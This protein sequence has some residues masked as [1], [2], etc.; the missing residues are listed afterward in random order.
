M[1]H[2]ESSGSNSDYFSDASDGDFAVV[3]LP[4]IPGAAADVVAAAA[5][6]GLIDSIQCDITHRADAEPCF[7]AGKLDAALGVGQEAQL[8]GMGD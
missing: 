4:H 3:D 5:A 6:A 2:E 7:M 8:D 1:Q